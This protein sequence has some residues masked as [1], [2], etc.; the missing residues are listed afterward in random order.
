MKAVESLEKLIKVDP[1]R[2]LNDQVVSN[3]VSIYDIQFPF[4]NQQKTALA[5]IIH[6][7]RIIG[8]LRKTSER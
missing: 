2:N 5:V 8:I 4:P 3:L 7:I 1:K 6:K